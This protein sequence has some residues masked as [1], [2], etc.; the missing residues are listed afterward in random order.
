MA[1][2]NL[3]FKILGWLGVVG[4]AAWSVYGLTGLFG[5][6]YLLLDILPSSWTL[7]KDLLYTG[8]GIGILGCY[9]GGKMFR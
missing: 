6:N 8:A 2:G 4:G 1:K 3:F 5:N 9:F 7:V